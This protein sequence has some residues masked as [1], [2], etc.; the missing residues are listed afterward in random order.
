MTKRV[1][2]DQIF[3][4]QCQPANALKH[5]F[6]N[7]VLDEFGLAVVDKAIS[8]TSDNPGSLFQLPQEQRPGVGTDPPTIESS[9]NLAPR[10]RMKLHTRWFTLCHVHGLSVGISLLVTKNETI[11]R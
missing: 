8:K 10:Q 6:I 2:I 1:V 3:V 7:T 11:S 9:H 5:Q 4:A